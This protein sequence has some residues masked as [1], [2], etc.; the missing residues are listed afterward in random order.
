MAFFKD[1]GK[2]F[3][4]AA[5]ETQKKASLLL[6]INKLNSAVRSEKDLIAKTQEK[7]GKAMYDMFTAGES[8]P[9][10][11]VADCQGISANLANITDL[12]A[13]IAELRHEEQKTPASEEPHQPAAGTAAPAA[14]SKFCSSCGAPLA[15]GAAFCGSCGQKNA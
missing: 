14:G 10:S 3:G 13:K 8:V 15:P 12:E 4:D 2:V 9:D 6:E 1:L 7:I 5:S 11:I